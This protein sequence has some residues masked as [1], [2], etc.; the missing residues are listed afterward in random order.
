M[1]YKGKIAPW[2][3]AVLIIVNGM[4]FCPDIFGEG[5]TTA[6]LIYVIIADFVLL[7]PVLRN[8]VRLEKDELI[9]CFGFGKDT[10]KVREIAEICPT[11]NPMAASLDGIVIKSKTG[12]SATCAVKKKEELFQELKKK[13]R[14]IKI[15]EDAKKKKKK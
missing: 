8:Y 2:Y 3:W 12:E 10:F 7:P 1:K 6:I 9:V 11:H 5:R 4:A 14:K 13:N 15:K